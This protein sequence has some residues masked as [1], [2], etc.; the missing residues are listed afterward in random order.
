MTL[1]QT[2]I[3]AASALPVYVLISSLLAGIIFQDNRALVFF[4]VLC[5]NCMLNMLLKYILWESDENAKRPPGGS[6]EKCGDKYGNPSGH[7]Q[8]VWFFST[9]WILYIGHSNVFSNN[10]ANVL[11]YISLVLIAILVCSSRIYLNC[12]NTHQVLLG[13]VVGIIFGIIA[14][15]STKTI[16]LEHV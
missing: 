6:V 10:T 7:S 1:S 13:S 8:F 2:I 15:Y 12:H 14:F 9:F 3:N 4:I 16:L 5:I 11:S